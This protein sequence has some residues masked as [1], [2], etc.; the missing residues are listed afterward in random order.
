LQAIKYSDSSLIAKIFTEAAGLQSYLV[1]GAYG[2]KSKFRAALFQPMT[3]V[4]FTGS[5]RP[6]K[7]L[8]FLTEIGLEIPFNTIPFNMQKNAVVLFVSELLTKTIREEEANPLLFDF[9]HRSM[10]WLDLC[11]G[12]FADFPLYFTLEL[13]RYLGFYP[14]P[15]MRGHRPVFDLLNGQFISAV[16]THTYYV[17]APLGEYLAN[18]CN[19]QLENIGSM[20][21]NNTHR[22]QLLGVLIDY[23]KLHVPGF[24]GMQSQEILRTVME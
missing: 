5:N 17:T 18:L 8:H 4:D 20:E 16:P 3:L 22:R 23:Y 12:K 9:I 1:K 10:E 24:R 15:E 21:L 13:S 14:K 11:Q 7:D 6:N 19:C 2:R